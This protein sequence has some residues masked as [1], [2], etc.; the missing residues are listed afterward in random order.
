MRTAVVFL[1]AYSPDFNP[2]EQVFAQLKAHLR[3][4]AARSFDALIDPI[5]EGFPRVCHSHIRAYYRHGGY[6]PPDDASQ[7]T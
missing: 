5:G 6:P 2:I 3:G 4:V 1:P 7:P